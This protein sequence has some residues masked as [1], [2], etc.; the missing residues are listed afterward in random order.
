MDEELLEE[1]QALREENDNLKNQLS[2]T[3]FPTNDQLTSEKNF[4]LLAGKDEIPDR[5]KAVFEYMLSSSTQWML[6]ES[7]EEEEYWAAMGMQAYDTF[8]FENPNCGFKVSDRKAIEILLRRR[9][10]KS[11]GGFE[12]TM[13]NTQIQ[14]IN[15]QTTPKLPDT[16]KHESLLQKLNP[17]R[18]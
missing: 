7:K 9:L 15:Y 12:R 13:I 16:P 18:R 4:E 10:N 6:I 5:Y 1:L 11:Y 17:F 3:D 2:M 8:M 14:E